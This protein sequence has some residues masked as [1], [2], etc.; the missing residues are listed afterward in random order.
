MHRCLAGF[1]GTRGFQVFLDSRKP[2]A[3]SESGNVFPRIRSKQSLNRFMKRIGLTRHHCTT[4]EQLT[5]FH[6]K[7]SFSLVIKVHLDYRPAVFLPDSF[8]AHVC[9]QE[10][11][12]NRFLRRH[13]PA[14]GMCISQVLFW[15]L[16]SS[17]LPLQ[18]WNASDSVNRPMFA[19][20]WHTSTFVYHQTEPKLARKQVYFIRIQS[21]APII[22]QLIWSVLLLFWV[23]FNYVVISDSIA[24]THVCSRKSQEKPTA[25]DIVS[26]V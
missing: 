15:V 6:P 11:T 9:S 20:S 12:K 24:V 22:C 17:K 25:I 3:I 2:V 13:P 8:S 10:I 19:F 5:K 16:S 1:S 23:F 14:L 18:H 7:M 21:H 26:Q 4:I